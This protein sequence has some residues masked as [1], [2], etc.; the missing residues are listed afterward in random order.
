M[1]CRGSLVDL[2]AQAQRLRQLGEVHRHATGR[3]AGER[4]GR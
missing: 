4:L 1:G 3:V 2:T